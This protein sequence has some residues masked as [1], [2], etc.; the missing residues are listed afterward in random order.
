MSELTPNDLELFARFRIAP[1]LLALAGVCRVTDREARE[2]FGISAG[3][4][5]DL[6]GIVFPYA[7]GNGHR[8]TCRLRRDFV[9]VNEKG[10]P[11]AK[12]LSPKGDSRHAYV[13]SSDM[14]QDVDTPALIVEAEK[15]VLAITAWAQRTGRKILPIGLGG[16]DGWSAKRGHKL[17]PNGGHEEHKGLLPELDYLASGRQ[18]RIIFDVN[19]QT[20]RRVLTARN[21]L[22]KHL[23]AQGAQVQV[24]NLPLIPNVNGP[25][26]FIA[27]QTDEAFFEL[28]NAPEGRPTVIVDP[29]ASGDAA[30]VAEQE[31]VKHAENLGIFERAGQVVRVVTLREPEASQGLRRP[32][33]TTLIEP[34]EQYQLL[35][36]LETLCD[37]KKTTKAGKLKSIDCPGRIASYYSGRTGTRL[38]PVLVGTIMTPLLRDDGTVLHE[39]GFD[40]LTGLFLISTE[41]WLPV[42]ETPSREDALEALA[43]LMEPFQ[44]FPFVAAADRSIL[45]AGLLTAVQRRLLFTAPLFAFSAPRQREGKSMLCDA[46][47][48]LATGRCAPSQYVSHLAEE[49]RK[50]VYTVLAEGLA[51]VSLDNLE[52]PLKSEALSMALTQDTY[53]DR[54]LGV[55]QARNLPTRVVWVA[56]G[57]NVAFRGDL[58]HRVLIARLDSRQEH[59]EQR[60]FEIPDLQEHLKARRPQMVRAVLTILKAYYLAPENPVAFVP[61]G[62]F[63]VWGKAV[64]API[65]WLGLPDPA[66][67]REATILDDPDQSSSIALLLALREAFGVL[68]FLMSKALGKAQENA[69]LRSAF[70]GVAEKSGRIDTRAVGWWTRRWKD[71]IT[72]GLCLR[73]EEVIHGAV[74][75]R[76]DVMV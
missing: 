47:S 60:R 8:A 31:L 38:L 54:T 29:G 2:D 16:A 51:V 76:I 67:T 5:H 11:A 6:A 27:A 41:A 56:S 9:P 14:L 49:F 58:A 4:E 22:V 72:E 53:R 50:A 25:D 35:E 30:N 21:K 28:L 23:K 17:M 69:N 19:V 20:N 75:W 63:D 43:I 59:P 42:P 66:E 13:L 62:G 15:S 12:Y 40:E 71:R 39:N 64:R 18:V 61:W 57:C 37:F 34:M 55:S 65:L 46:L 52:K 45:L 3:S 70:L 10:R 48:I 32:V 7:G 26:D 33:G 36:A 73:Q 24:I 68:P 1:G 44:Q 74:R